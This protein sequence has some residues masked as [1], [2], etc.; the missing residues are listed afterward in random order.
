MTG[1]DHRKKTIES[2][3]ESGGWIER[4]TGS[5]REGHS[6]WRK[7]FFAFVFWLFCFCFT[8]HVSGDVS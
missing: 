8:W 3:K 7:L 6:V 2:K 4:H 1:S 5:R